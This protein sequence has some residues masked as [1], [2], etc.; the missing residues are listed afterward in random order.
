MNLS[1]SR[2]NGVRALAT[3]ALLVISAATAAAPAQAQAQMFTNV[4]AISGKLSVNAGDVGDNITIN[5]DGNSLVVR[6]F[7]DTITAGS[8]TCTN[9]DVRTVR[10]DSAGITSILVNSKGGADTVANNTGLQSRVFLGPGVDVFTGGSARDFVN[11]DGSSDRI[12]GRGGSDII[13]GDAGA[14]DL[15]DGGTGTDFC[16]A[17]TETSCEGDA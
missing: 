8:F 13:I 3:G 12:L 1:I 2:R 17:E 11:G 15:A 7:N 5:V 10:C 14:S 6:N 4:T 9:V 16:N